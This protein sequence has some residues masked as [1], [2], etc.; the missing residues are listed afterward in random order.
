MSLR[1]MCLS[2]QTLYLQF[3][4]LESFCIN[5]ITLHLDK[6]LGAPNTADLLVV[7]HYFIICLFPVYMMVFFL[8]VFR[9]GKVKLVLWGH[10]TSDI[11]T[12]R[13]LLECAAPLLHF[14]SIFAQSL[15]S[16]LRFCHF[17]E[18]VL[19]QICKCKGIHMK[20]A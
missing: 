14:S 9:G 17:R 16:S 7:R 8:L 10:R 18:K 20:L 3:A 12:A 1:S 15:K 2:R 11:K 5:H 13:P 19:S 6:L 4:R